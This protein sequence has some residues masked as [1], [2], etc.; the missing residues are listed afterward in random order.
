[1]IFL[2]ITLAS[3]GVG[4]GIYGELVEQRRL[5]RMAQECKS[6]EQQS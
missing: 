6:R 4:I 1:M 3:L 5:T 2:C